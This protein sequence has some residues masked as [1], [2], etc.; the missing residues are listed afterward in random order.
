MRS[1]RGDG[2][3]GGIGQGESERADMDRY[4][5]AVENLLKSE[6]PLASA[7]VRVQKFARVF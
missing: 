6:K 2:W 1:E 5:A 3:S 4:P 7:V